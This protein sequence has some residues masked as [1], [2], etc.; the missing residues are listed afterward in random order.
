MAEAREGVREQASGDAGLVQAVGLLDGTMIVASAED[1]IQHQ[2][3]GTET[4][5]AG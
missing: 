1:R 2:T 3:T 4:L 5:E